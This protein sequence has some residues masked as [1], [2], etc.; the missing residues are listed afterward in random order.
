MFATGSTVFPRSTANYVCVLKTQCYLCWSCSL[1]S[2]L[3]DF[4]LRKLSA[5]ALMRGHT[6]GEFAIQHYSKPC[7]SVTKLAT[8]TECKNAKAALDPT[9]S[10]VKIENY[11]GAP[12]G[13]SRYG[14]KWYFNSHV[15]GAL[16]GA[17]EPVCKATP[18]KTN[19]VYLHEFITLFARAC[20]TCS[21][22]RYD[23]CALT[24]LPF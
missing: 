1:L 14:G 24:A 11:E 2:T 5:R 15:K 6:A 7:T 22:S 13:C 21:V 10:A 19:S 17:S 16:D 4:L 23:G 18:G 9:D 20:Y 8:L 12:S 3:A